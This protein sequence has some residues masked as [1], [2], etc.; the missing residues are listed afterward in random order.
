MLIA[1]ACA[2]PV[3]QISSVAADPARSKLRAIPVTNG[4][5]FM[6][7]F[8]APTASHALVMALLRSF[9]KRQLKVTTNNESL[10]LVSTPM[11]LQFLLKPTDLF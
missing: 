11:R 5:L 4:R 7:L 2:S 9:R 8:L 10:G 6:V 3:A 1:E